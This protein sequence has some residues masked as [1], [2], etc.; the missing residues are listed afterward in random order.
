MKKRLLITVLLS[1]FFIQ[2][3]NSENKYLPDFE[4]VQDTSSILFSVTNLNEPEAVRYAPVQ[5]VFFISNFNGSGNGRDGNG[6][7]TKV[8]TDGNVVDTTF[9]TGT[10]EFPLHAPRGMFNLGNSLFAADVDGVHEFDIKSGEQ[11][12]FYDFSEFEPG[13]LNDISSDGKGTLFV[14]DTGKPIVYSITDGGVEIFLD[15]LPVYP[16]GITYDSANA[17][18]VLAPWRGDSLFYSFDL[19][20]NLNQSYTFEGGFFDGIEFSDGMLIAA[21]QS[22][23]SIKIHN[24]STS[25]TLIKTAGRPADIGIDTTNKIIAVPYIALDRVDFWS[26]RKNNI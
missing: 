23:S 7:I 14:T 5:N 19:D 13:F 16:N 22:D 17:Q 26:Y 15:E 10:E 11:I 25:R 6:F 18:F 12:N 9:M 20:G 21:T 1:G 8:D 4:T 2:C 3:N 24:G